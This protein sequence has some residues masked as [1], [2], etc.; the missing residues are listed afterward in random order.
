[1]GCAMVGLAAHSLTAAVAGINPKTAQFAF[2]EESPTGAQTLRLAVFDS[3]GSR[4]RAH[5]IATLESVDGDYEKIH[6]LVASP[7]NAY[8]A[9]YI[10]QD[11]SSFKLP[12]LDHNVRLRSLRHG[13]SLGLINE[14]SFSVLNRSVRPSARLEEYLSDLIALGM[15]DAAGA[16]DYDYRVDVDAG[17]IPTPTYRW[18]RDGTFSV[19]FR[20]AVIAFV[21]GETR[22][23]HVGDELFTRTYRVSGTA[24]AVFVDWENT[25]PRP[26]FRDYYTLGPVYAPAGALVTWETK[27]V[28]FHDPLLPSLPARFRIATMV[29]GNIAPVYR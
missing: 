3:V 8:F 20:F 4:P 26:Y 9:T 7:D 13:T 15:L 22:E 5:E 24:V 14:H 11:G 21:P 19:T 12:F 6:D 18:N 10:F 27:V 23:E 2:V 1:M 28:H 16:A 17:D 29:E 25:R